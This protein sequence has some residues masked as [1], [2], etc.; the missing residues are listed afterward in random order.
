M[1]RVSPRPYVWNAAYMDVPYPKLYRNLQNT[2]TFAYT[3]RE[4]SGT[5]YC[6]TTSNRRAWPGVSG[7]SVSTRRSAFVTAGWRE[8]ID[9][10]TVK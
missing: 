2:Q 5:N 10:A 8:L 3:P 4:E 7:C 9:A 1:T 6:T